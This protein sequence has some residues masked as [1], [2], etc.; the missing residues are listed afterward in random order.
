M[1]ADHHG[2]DVKRERKTK[3][4]SGVTARRAGSGKDE[5][6]RKVVR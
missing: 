6:E 3:K 2:E 1:H 4:I 5:E